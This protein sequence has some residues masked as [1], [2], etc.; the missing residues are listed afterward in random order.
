MGPATQGGQKTQNR[1]NL[2]TR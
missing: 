1:A 2:E